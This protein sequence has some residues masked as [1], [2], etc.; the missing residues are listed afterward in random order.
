MCKHSTVA[1]IPFRT[2]SKGLVNKNFRLLDGVPLWERAAMQ[3][4][5]TCSTTICTSDADDLIL[6]TS[7]TG[8]TFDRRPLDLSQDNSEMKYVIRY[9]IKKF[10]LSNRICVLLQPTSPMRSDDSVSEALNIYLNGAWSMVMSVKKASNTVL[11]Y[12]F[13]VD[14]AF[15]SI[16]D[17]TFCFSNRQELP[18]VV[19]P[20]GAIYIFR[21]Q[22]FLDSDDFP[23]ENIGLYEMDEYESHDLDTEADF[24]K[25][26]SLTK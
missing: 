22:D 18:N 21:G 1:I 3:G 11:K 6:G 15:K 7:V 12:G 10:D 23:Y 5:R 26:E 24:Q 9:I 2:G 20:N 14:G 4:V 13:N 8:I 19:A 16:N 25:I 17:P